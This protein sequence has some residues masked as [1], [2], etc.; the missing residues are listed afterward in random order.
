[1]GWLVRLI[2]LSVLGI[3]VVAG[4]KRKSPKWALW[5]GLI[6]M[7]VLIAVAFFPWLLVPLAFLL[8]AFGVYRS[9]FR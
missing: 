1:M 8:L 4:V 3:A 5:A 2:F 6:G 7:P 9:I